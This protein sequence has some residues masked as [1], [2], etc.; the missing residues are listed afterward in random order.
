MHPLII[1]LLTLET[2]ICVFTL[3][4]FT[5]VHVDSKCIINILLVH[6]HS[7]FFLLVLDLKQ[8]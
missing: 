2:I 4:F 3:H 6:P 5:D 7:I 8:F 1:L